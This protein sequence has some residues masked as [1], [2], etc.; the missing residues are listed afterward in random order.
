MHDAVSILLI[1]PHRFRCNLN[2][3]SS[4]TPDAK[5]S[6]SQLSVSAHSLRAISSLECISA[7][8]WGYCASVILAN[9]LDEDFF[10]WKTVLESILYYAQSLTILTAN[11]SLY[12]KS[13]LRFISTFPRSFVP[14]HAVGVHG[15]ARFA[16]V[17]N[18]QLVAVWNHLKEVHG[19]KTEGERGIQ[20]VGWIH[21]RTSRDAIQR[22]KL[23][24]SI[25]SP[26]VLDKKS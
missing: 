19:I 26:S 20:P 6:L 1:L 5:I 18:P 13:K 15:I 25:P 11:S 16:S 22:A 12:S 7:R 24:D 2:V 4:I 23:V 17:W 10:I 21:A 9:T 14:N 8:L 3:C